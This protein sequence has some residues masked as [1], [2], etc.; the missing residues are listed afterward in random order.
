VT[1]S[2]VAYAERVSILNRR[3]TV[4]THR[5]LTFVTAQVLWMSIANIVLGLMG[6]WSLKTYFV[7]SFIGLLVNRVLFTPPRTTR[8]WGFVRLTT[9]LG[10]VV[11]SYVFYL[12]LESLSTG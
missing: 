10:F 4:M 6:R 8:W 1:V 5:P 2:L 9:W 7:V 3:A 11:F 12:R